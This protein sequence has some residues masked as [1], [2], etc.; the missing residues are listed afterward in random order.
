MKKPISFILIAFTSLL[1]IISCV[2]PSFEAKDISIITESASNPISLS[3][4]FPNSTNNN[5][6]TIVTTWV[7]TINPLSISNTSQLAIVQAIV[8]STQDTFELLKL[9]ETPQVNII[10]ARN[11]IGKP[12]WIFNGDDCFVYGYFTD[13]GDGTAT[14]NSADAATQSLMNVC[15]YRNVA[16][17]STISI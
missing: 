7:N 5:D 3:L 2:N 16:L 13:H 10:T 9:I 8:A 4:P 14:F 17:K 6:T 11:Q 1:L 15:G 12:G